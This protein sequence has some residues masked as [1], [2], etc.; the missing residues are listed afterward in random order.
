MSKIRVEYKEKDNYWIDYGEFDANNDD[1]T[2]SYI[3]VS[4]D[5]ISVRLYP[6]EFHEYIE[7]RADLMVSECKIRDYVSCDAIYGVERSAT[8]SLP[9]FGAD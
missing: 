6:V 1:T 5:A 4:F 7:L 3:P 8:D 2:R 9:N